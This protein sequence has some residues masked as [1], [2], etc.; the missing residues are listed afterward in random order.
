MPR[1]AR[2]RQ[3]FEPCGPRARAKTAQD[4]HRRANDERCG[5][6]PGKERRPH[7]LP[8]DLRKRLHVHEHRQPQDE[9]ESAEDRIVEL[10]FA[11]PTAFITLPMSASPFAMYFAKSSP[12]A[13]WAPKPRCVRKSLYSL[14]S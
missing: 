2:P 8:G 10:H 3:R 9:Q 7:V 6:Q 14:L 4:Q 11:M 5:D 1:R 13:H 12:F